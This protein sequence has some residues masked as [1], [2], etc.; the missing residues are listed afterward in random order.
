MELLVEFVL[1]IV[2]EG[3]MEAGKS[4]KIP[5]YVRYPLL[6]IVVLFFTAVIGVTFFAGSLAI[7][8]NIVAGIALF[9]LGLFML[10]ACIV[11]FKKEYFDKANINHEL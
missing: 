5:K 6:V 8:K 3:C 1:S 11:K 10:T 9:L 4:S 2:L 7:Q